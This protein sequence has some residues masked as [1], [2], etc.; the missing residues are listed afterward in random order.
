M[1]D[2]LAKYSLVLCVIAPLLAVLTYSFNFF[3]Q[4]I[5]D[6]SADWG[7]LGDFFGGVLNPLIAFCALV[8]LKYS[9]KIQKIELQE[10][11]NELKA[12]NAANE[13]SLKHNTNLM[14]VES[15]RY[16]L[17]L[18]EQEIKS[19][20]E[21][22]FV[23]DV[24]GPNNKKTHKCSLKE[25]LMAYGRNNSVSNTYKE[26]INT[27]SKDVMR[28]HELFEMLGFALIELNKL[29]SHSDNSYPVKFYLFKYKYLILGI[30][31]I[32][33]ITPCIIDLLKDDPHKELL[34]IERTPKC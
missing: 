12:S 3:D 19:R 4:P 11:R 30:D 25:M 18:A 21:L 33:K 16:F 31:K 27:K 5:S 1:S 8:W 23:Y 15:I 32:H 6:S 28:L 13:Q 9:V 7:A 14:K 22:N 34:S 2:K 26:G 10:L 20:I 17:K 24:G 29:E